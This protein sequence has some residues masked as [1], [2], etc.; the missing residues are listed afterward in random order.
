[1]LCAAELGY[2]IEM[3]PADLEIIA[4]LTRKNF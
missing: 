2:D 1:M 3:D 4:V